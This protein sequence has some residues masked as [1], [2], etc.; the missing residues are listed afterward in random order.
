MIITLQL[1]VESTA[2]L[3]RLCESLKPWLLDCGGTPTVVSTPAPQHEAPAVSNG[4]PDVPSA[5]PRCPLHPGEILRTFTKN[6]RQWK[7]HRQ[8]EGWCS[9]KAKS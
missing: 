3:A 8:G 6:G 5:M 4:T 7:A 9:G 1:K 2:D